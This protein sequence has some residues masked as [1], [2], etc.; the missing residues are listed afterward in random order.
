MKIEKEF[1][2]VAC[3][4]KEDLQDTWDIHERYPLTEE[5]LECAVTS[6]TIQ[7]ELW[8]DVFAHRVF[9]AKV[10]T[11]LFVIEKEDIED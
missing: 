6:A 2:V 7:N 5:G 9:R 8:E 3:I 1:Y 4:S 10:Q 11:E